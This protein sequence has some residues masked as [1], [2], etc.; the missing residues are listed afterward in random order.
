[1][2][3]FHLG[4]LGSKTFVGDLHELA[5]DIGLAD[6]SFGEGESNP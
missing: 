3:V 5:I 6:I 2:E 1:M 4:V